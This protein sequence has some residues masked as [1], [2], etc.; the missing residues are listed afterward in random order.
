[1][2]VV[3]VPR[4]GIIALVGR[5]THLGCLVKWVHAADYRRFEQHPE[6]TF[7]DP[8]GGSLFALNGDCLGGP[9]PR[10]LDRFS[11][12]ENGT[13][14]SVNVSDVNLGRKRNPTAQLDPEG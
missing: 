2:F 14:L 6:V 5:S 12:T 13:E 9:C 3:D 11:A 7:E 8:C 1:V 10:G 4:E